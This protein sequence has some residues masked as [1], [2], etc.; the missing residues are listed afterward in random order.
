MRFL[1]SLLALVTFAAPVAAE[2]TEC[3]GVDPAIQG[4]W[5][6]D[7][8][9][10]DKGVTVIPEHNAAM[11]RVNALSLKFPNG[12][13]RK[14]RKVMFTPADDKNPACVAFVFYENT[15]MWV[16]SDVSPGRFLLQIVDPTADYKEDAR[17]LFTVGN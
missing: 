7:C 15:S 9:S 13:L 8:S 5:Y 1:L 3:L 14:I 16:V 17:F 6:V 10:A 12:E 11:V 4:V 2:T